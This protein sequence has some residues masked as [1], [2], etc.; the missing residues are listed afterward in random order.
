[1]SVPRYSIVV[2][3]Y[4]AAAYVESAIRSALLQSEHDLEVIVVDDGSED[5]TAARVRR[6]DDERVRLIEQTNRGPSAARN[7]GIAAAR[8]DLVV[9][10]DSDDLLL[11]EYLE[12][13]GRALA[14]APG[15]GFAYTDAWVLDAASGRVRRTTMTSNQRPPRTPPNE[16][17]AFFALLL[18][19]NFVCPT[20]TVRREALGQVGGFDERLWRAEEWELWLRLTAAGFG[21]SR[22]ARTL[23]VHRDRSG[24]LSTDLA[25]MIEGIR[26]VYRI[27]AEEYAVDEA[28]K[29][30]ARV[31]RAAWQRYV[32]SAIDRSRRPTVRERTLDLARAAKARLQAPRLWL[33]EPPRKVT[34]LLRRVE[35]HPLA[36]RD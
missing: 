19:R 12:L 9:M 5:D 30:R 14:A 17:A 11:P 8:G 4:N 10:L 33:A 7:R 25:K 23:A 21:A 16:P 34:E 35:P 3:A 1:V 15:A 36:G 28:L 27:V 26:E 2:P 13:M 20:V 29:E 31:R 22:A 6:I 24:S 32:E 18:E